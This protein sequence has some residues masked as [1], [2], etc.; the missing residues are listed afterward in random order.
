M[1]LRIN[2]PTVATGSEKLEDWMERLVKLIP[3]EVVSVFLLLR[4]FGGEAWQE[5]IW[6]LAFLLLTFVFRAYFTQEGKSPQWMAAGIAT[7]AFIFWVYITGG[8][9]FGWEVDTQIMTGIMLVY[10]LVVSKVYKGD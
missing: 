7:F 6:P 8:N 9:F 2:K 3:G 1:S 5:I 10:M 4:G